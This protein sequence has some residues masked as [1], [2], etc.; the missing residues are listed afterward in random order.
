MYCRIR[1]KETN[2]QE[3]HIYRILD[4]SSFGRCLE[5]YKQYVEYKG[6]EDIVPIFK[7]EFELNHSRKPNVY[8]D[9]ETS[10]LYAMRDIKQDKELLQYYPP[11]ERMWEHN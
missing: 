11:N 3:Y 1:L 10:S 8:Y 7:E 9:S 5:I 6:F 4:S 2:Y